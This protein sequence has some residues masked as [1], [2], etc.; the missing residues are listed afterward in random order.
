[1]PKPHAKSSTFSLI[2]AIK[3][4]METLGMYPSKLAKAAKM[5][6]S[7]LCQFLNGKRELRL[8]TL[9]KVGKALGLELV[10]SLKNASR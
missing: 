1:M 8:E 6:E 10:L 3:D 4:R 2:P 5:G 9:R 7:G